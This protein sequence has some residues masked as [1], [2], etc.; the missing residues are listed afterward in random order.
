MIVLFN[1]FI[2]FS[3]VVLYVLCTLHDRTRIVQSSTLEIDIREI[4][5]NISWIL[6]D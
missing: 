3:A 4:L 1:V 6:N 2:R 5:G